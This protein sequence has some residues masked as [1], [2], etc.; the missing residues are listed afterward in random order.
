MTARHV[1]HGAC[2]VKVFVDGRW[3]GV[4]S[5]ISWYTRGRGDIDVADVTTI[6]L[7]GNSEG[8]VFP[9]RSWSMAIG[10]NVAALGHP[11]GNNI[12]LNQGKVAWKGHM[13]TVPML[14][15]A[16]L[17]AAGG[18]GSPLV[19]E[20]GEVVGI[21]QIGLTDTKASL[22]SGR[23]L[24]IDLP[25]W[26]PTAKR[27]LCKTYRYGGI[28][29]CTTTGPT[30]KPAPKPKPK[31]TPPPPP[32]PTEQV[33]SDPS[34]DAG[35]APDIDTVGVT[36]DTLGDITFDV[37]VG[38]RSAPSATDMIAV[39][40]DADQNRS[41]GD[42]TGAEYIAGVSLGGALLLKWDGAQFSAF[43][44]GP[45][46]GSVTGNLATLTIHNSDV[47]VGSAFNFTVISG[48]S[49]GGSSSDIDVAPDGGVWTYTMR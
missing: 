1:V 13:G 30:P 31:P 44:H 20:D 48:M 35:A 8:H 34:G 21:L 11:L 14:G 29:G 9:I 4:K 6:K 27:N 10:Q 42:P 36:N 17:S 22:T 7:S 39:A 23:I 2:R 19:D 37:A 26:W 45:V 43:D 49:G 3:L 12:S 46:T 41:T 25:S 32:A 5:T 24:G 15:V 33:T 40:I 38:N 16:M 47:Q 18:S 28:P